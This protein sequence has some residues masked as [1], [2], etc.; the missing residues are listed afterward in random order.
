[1][2]KIKDYF[3]PPKILVLGFAALIIAGAVLLSLPI[4]THDGQGLPLLNALFTATSATCV[5]GLVVVD[6]SD[7][8]TTFG[9]L[10]IL[11]LIQ[12]GGLGFMTFATFFAFI[13]GKRVSF[14]DRLVLQEALNNI[15]LEGIVRLVKRVLIFSAIIE[16]TGAAILSIRFSFEMPIGKAIYWGIFHS[17]SNFNNAGFDLNGEFRS[18]TP[19]V[20]DPAVVLTVCALITLGGIGFIVM[21]EIYEYHDTG[22]LSVHTKVVLVSSLIL[23]LGAAILIFVFE[24]GNSK[25]I[26][27]LSSTGKVLGSL[28]QSVTARTAGANTLPIGDLTQS[29]L[30][31]LIFLMYIGAGPGSTAGGIKITTLAVLASTVWTQ[32]RGREDV[33]LFRR[34]IVLE[35]ILKAL[36]VA[37]MGMFLIMAIT[38]ILTITEGDQHNFIMYLFEASSAFGTVGLSMGLT[39]ELTPIGKTVIIFTMFAGRL[40]P[41]TLAYALTM[42][43]KG[44][45]EPVG[46][47]KGKIMIG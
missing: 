13:L 20:D 39:P 1:M 7:T 37:V 4:A 17:I 14:K 25:T 16:L 28:F 34:K 47:P 26:E 19:F 33:V 30:F 46:Y 21:N 41:L 32:I 12:I 18:L 45:K 35:T 15:S 3:D 36:T 42:R 40:G 10:V 22:R 43:R 23:T 6:T 38:M 27:P 31:L 11:T 9:E 29:T 2:K 44:K 5:T 8:F 24:L